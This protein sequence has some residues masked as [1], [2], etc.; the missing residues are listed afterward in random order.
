MS[1]AAFVIVST[2]NHLVFGLALFIPLMDFTGPNIV[3]S[4]AQNI[5]EFW[6]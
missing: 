1:S 6:Y 3:D 5:D 2:N 4:L